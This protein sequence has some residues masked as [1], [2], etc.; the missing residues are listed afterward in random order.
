MN[1]LTLRSLFILKKILSGT[2]VRWLECLRNK[3]Y[4]SVVF[5]FSFVL[6]FVFIF[7]LL[8]QNQSYCLVGLSCMSH[9]LFKFFVSKTE[10][11]M[12]EWLLK[13]KVK[14]IWVSDKLQKNLHNWLK[15]IWYIGIIHIIV[16]KREISSIS[17]GTIEETRALI[18]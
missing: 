15:Q 7:C 2:S 5:V 18:P 13:P 17:V 10:L 1:I 11:Q 8:F 4:T 6:F 14:K 3:N 16:I 12:H 9:R